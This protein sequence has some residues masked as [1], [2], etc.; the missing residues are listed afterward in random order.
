MRKDYRKEAYYNRF[1]AGKDKPTICCR[2]RFDTEVDD[3]AVCLICFVR[4]DK[5]DKIW[6][7]LYKGTQILPLCGEY[8]QI[9][10][11]LAGED[12]KNGSARSIPVPLKTALTKEEYLK[13]RDEP[14]IA[15]DEDD[16]DTDDDNLS[17]HIGSQLTRWQYALLLIGFTSF[18]S[19]GFRSQLVWS[20]LY[21][22]NGTDVYP[23]MAARIYLAWSIPL[24]VFNAL[25][26][27]NHRTVYA[28]FIFGLCPLGLRSISLLRNYSLTIMWIAIALLVV[29]VGLFFWMSF[30]SGI[31]MRN[32]LEDARI[33]GASIL[34]LS[35]TALLIADTFIPQLSVRQIERPSTIVT[36]EEK[37]ISEESRALLNSDEWS[38]AS[39]ERK[40]QALYEVMEEV[41]ADFGFDPPTMYLDA[42]AEGSY[43]AYYQWEDHTIHIWKPALEH[44]SA[45]A[46]VNTILHETFHAY[47]NMLIH[48][49]AINWDD[50]DMQKLSYLKTLAQWRQDQENYV[51][52]DRWDANLESY[53]E[54]SLEADAYLFAEKY[55]DYYFQSDDEEEQITP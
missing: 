53:Y 48:S 21:L 55:T 16:P 25:A 20:S 3:P 54:Q 8:E 40:A 38:S 45:A 35:F 19:V 31:G 17:A 4:E 29:A 11:D 22:M 32:S 13:Y 41:C 47:Q 37:P 27:R 1:Y 24:T 26:N 36:Q 12:W 30:R 34:V 39:A 50:P 52:V 42:Q 10:Q 51:D 15:I 2:E 5:P 9:A 7:G 46:A 18:L 23:S 6:F 33:L 28:I 43:A 49:T 14:R 44:Y